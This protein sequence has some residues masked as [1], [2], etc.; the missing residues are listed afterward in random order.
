MPFEILIDI[1]S[2]FGFSDTSLTENAIWDKEFLN[3]LIEWMN[4]DSWEK[5]YGLD[6]TIDF[7]LSLS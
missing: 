4:W 2:T 6:A 7:E 1:D 5:L 3:H